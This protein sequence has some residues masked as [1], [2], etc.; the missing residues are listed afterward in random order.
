MVCKEFFVVFIIICK[1]KIFEKNW[2]IFI[3]FL[4]KYV[5][6]DERKYYEELFKYS[7]DYFMLYFYYLSDIMVKGLRIILFLYYIGIMEVS[8]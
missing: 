8:L 7:R 1:Y 3:F 6:K 4:V 5:K 2:R